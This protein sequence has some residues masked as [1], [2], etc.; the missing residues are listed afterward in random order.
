[1]DANLTHA[2]LAFALLAAPASLGV[3]SQTDAVD[4]PLIASGDE[5]AEGETIETFEGDVAEE[6]TSGVLDLRIDRGSVK[7]VGWEQDRYE[8]QV[9]QESTD[10]R[11]DG[12]TTTEFQETVEDDKL[13]LELVVDRESSVGSPVGT[14]GQEVGSDAPERAIVA[15]VPQSLDYESIY[16]CEGQGYQA[17]NASLPVS[18]RSGHTECVNSDQPLDFQPRIHVNHRGD[19]GLNVTSGLVGIDGT[20]AELA[21]DNN[22]I[23]LAEIGFETLVAETDNGGIEGANVTTQQLAVH[24]DNGHVDLGVDAES[25]DV[26]MDNGHVTLVGE[27]GTIDARSDNGA[28]DVV[29]SAIAEGSIVTDN[30]AIEVHLDPAESGDLSLETDNGAIEAF[31]AH[32]EDVGYFAEGASDNGDVDI[33]LVDERS[34]DDDDPTEEH[35]RY[36]EHEVAHTA[37]YEGKDIQFGITAETDNGGIQILEETASLEDDEDEDTGTALVDS[38][39]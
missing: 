4:V 37:G 18:V 39:R 32:S 29:S 21:F 10:G 16:A 6:V 34:A 17:P 9:L 2:L 15:H 22:P 3:A 27:I 20:Q 35:E 31:L 26:H 14:Q 25:A 30:G 7:V 11:S 8:I 24:T 13:T 19:D 12:E 36:G 33:A 23:V 28:I 1:M 5:A 38:L